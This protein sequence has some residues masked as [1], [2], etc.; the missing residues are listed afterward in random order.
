M[1]S[2]GSYTMPVISVEEMVR[3]YRAG[4]SLLD[5][6]LR[7]KLNYK[8]VRTLLMAH[9]CPIR[10]QK[11]TLALNGAKRAPW[12]QLMPGAKGGET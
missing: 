8:A 2:R 10:T 12:R 11:E 1:T 9:G 5:V 4:E 3:R 7:A 6:S